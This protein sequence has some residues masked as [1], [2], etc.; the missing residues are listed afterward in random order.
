[1]G[2]PGKDARLAR[3]GGGEPP[4]GPRS[5][6]RVTLPRT[7]I[8]DLLQSITPCDAGRVIERPQPREA[9]ILLR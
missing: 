7:R 3:D 9:G 8:S 4:S 6:P 2:S 1:M 5:V